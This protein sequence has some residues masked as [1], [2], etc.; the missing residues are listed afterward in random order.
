M[1]QASIQISGMSCGHCVAAV[2]QALGSLSGVQVES[3]DIGSARIQYD[4]SAIT[5]DH[6]TGAI[7]EEGYPAT[8][9]NGEASHERG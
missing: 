6:I 7:E 5:P 8:L 1:K 3:V 4:P 9:S 2:K